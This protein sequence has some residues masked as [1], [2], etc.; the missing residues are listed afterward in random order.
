MV[1]VADKEVEHQIAGTT[2]HGLYNVVR[3]RR[4]PGVPDSDGVEGLKVMNEV[5]GPAL[6]LNTEPT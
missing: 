1:V 5:Q 6:F 3:I 4:E 2:H